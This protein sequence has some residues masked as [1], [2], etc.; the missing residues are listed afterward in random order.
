MTLE[1][2]VVGIDGSE[3]SL[4]AVT[5]AAGLLQS[6]NARAIATHVVSR[7]WLIELSALQIDTE[8][9]IRRERASLV[10]PW[11]SAFREASV[12]YSTELA[13]GDPATELIRVATEHHADAIIIG[14]THHSGVRD[15]LLG[16]TAHRVVNR[17]GLP[18]MVVPFPSAPR[19]PRTVPIPG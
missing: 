17:C 19:P 8:D 18:V 11:T 2:A 12:N 15:A 14:G 13:Q 5:W 1:T 10:G 4:H 3:G 6:L 9:L 7:T 16:G